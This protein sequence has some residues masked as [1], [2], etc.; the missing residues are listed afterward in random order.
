ME[1]LLRIYAS[2]PTNWFKGLGRIVTDTHIR[3]FLPISD[4]LAMVSYTDSSDAKYWHKTLKQSEKILC[5]KIQKQLKELFPNS[6][7]PNPLF[8]KAHYWKTG[9]TY[10]L[11]GNYD[12]KKESLKSIHPFDKDIFIVGESFS[13]KQAW[14]EGALE[15][16]EKFF[17][18]YY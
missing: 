16:C 1:P 7:I 15:Q 10:W 11:P 13:L 3:Y 9:A 6:S 8:F 5:D 18:T 12:V 4:R 2:Y 17:Q 14:M